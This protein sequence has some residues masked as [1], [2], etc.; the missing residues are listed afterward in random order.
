MNNRIQLSI[1]VPGGAFKKRIYIIEFPDQDFLSTEN[2]N[3]FQNA[4][5]R[6]SIYSAFLHLIKNRKDKLKRRKKKIIFNTI[7]GKATRLILL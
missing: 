6:I 5:T 3:S 4:G 2:Q 7:G 1:Y